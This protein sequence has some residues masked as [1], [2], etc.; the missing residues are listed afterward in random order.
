MKIAIVHDY[1]DQYGGAE[2]VVEAM[3]EVFPEA[4]VY[5]SIYFPE[6][7]PQVFK[8]MDI[9]TSFMQHFPY[10]KRHMKKYYLIYPWVFRSFDLSKYDVVLSSSSAY[11]KGVRVRKDALHICYCHAPARFIWNFNQYMEKEK[12][13]LMAKKI[14]YFMTK[15]CLKRWDIS[16]SKKV[17]YFIANSANIQSK[18]K[19]IYGMDSFI[20]HPPVESQK[21][22]LSEKA[23]E[24]FLVVSRLAAYKRIDL[25]IRVFNKLGFPLRVIGGGSYLEELKK[26]A[27]KNIIFLGKVDEIRLSDNYSHCQALIFPGEEDFGITS[28]EAQASGRPVIAYGK[29]GA[30]E[31]IIDGRTGIFFFEQTEEA[32]SAAIHKYIKESNAFD[33]SVIRESALRFCVSRFKE[34]IKRFVLEKYEQKKR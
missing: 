30:L 6:N 25:V 33:P 27:G 18:I 11:A 26:I 1:L 32:L 12:L 19:S 22:Y 13:P 16:S 20:I 7:L 17:D 28:L 29:G 8:S 21:F 31:S 10:I 5:T 2:R 3:H 23:D 34:K 4:P 9:R 15:L 24:Y 14:I